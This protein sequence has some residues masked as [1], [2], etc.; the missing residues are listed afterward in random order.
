MRNSISTIFAGASTR[1]S[2]LK[3]YCISN[4]H[5]YSNLVQYAMYKCGLNSFLRSKTCLP[6]R[7]ERHFLNNGD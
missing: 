1:I 3:N 2:A 6:A 7:S 4:L 5:L